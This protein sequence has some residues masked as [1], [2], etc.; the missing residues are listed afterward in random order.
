MTTLVSNSMR[1]GPLMRRPEALTRVSLGSAVD[2]LGRR[3]WRLGWI[4]ARYGAPP[5]WARRPGFATLLRIILEQQVSLDSARALYRR[6][7]DVLPGVTPASIQRL[8]AAGLQQ[9]GFTRQKASYACH[10]AQRVF[11][12]ELS[13]SRLGRYPDELACEQLMCVTGIG[14]WT[15]SIYLLMALRRNGCRRQV[16]LSVLPSSGVPCGRWLPGFSGTGISRSGRA[17]WPLRP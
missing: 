16:R 13:L 12:G 14:P 6:L 7:A 1:R 2:A 5:L 8:G 17:G 3:D 10:L 9:L 4:V 11:E 15:A